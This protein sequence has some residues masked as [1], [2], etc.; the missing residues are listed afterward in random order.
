MDQGFSCPTCRSPLRGKYFKDGRAEQG[1]KSLNIHCTNSDSGCQWVGP[2]RDI[3]SHIKADCQYQ[4]V[5]CPNKCG[6]KVM[7]GSLEMHMT[8]SCTEYFVNCQYCKRKGRYLLINS[9]HLDECPDLPIQCSNEACGEM[10][11]RRSLASHKETCPKALVP[12]Q[13]NTVGCNKKIKREEQESHNDEALKEHLE[14]TMKKIDTAMK[15]IE[16]LCQ[17]NQV[18]KLS[19]YREKKDSNEDWYGPCFYTSPGGYKMPLNVLANGQGT[20]KGTHVSFFVCLMA[21]EYDDSLEWPFQG[22][23][24]VELL[25]QLEDQNHKKITIQYN[26]STEGPCKN[27]SNP[28]RAELKDGG[29]GG[30]YLM[31]SWSITQLLTVSI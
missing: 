11:P 17:T 12:C 10:I 4:R 3:G 29:G 31:K 26:E 21:G 1:I 19:Q 22:E 6:Q 30:S 23:V 9:S 16:V 24:T 8:G 20:S 5:Y 18:I 28:N 14:A 13:Y 25:N 27:G 15:K 2:I 7:R